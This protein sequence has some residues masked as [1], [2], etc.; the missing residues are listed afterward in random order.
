MKVIQI[1]AEE[2]NLNVTKLAEKIGVSRPTIYA[3][4]KGQEPSISDTVKIARALG[5][6][7]VTIYRDYI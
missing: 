1:K 4:Y 7:P 5:I 2:L 3:W 6:S